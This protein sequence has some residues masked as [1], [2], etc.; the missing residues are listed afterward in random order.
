MSGLKV[1]LPQFILN[2]EFQ[3]QTPYFELQELILT[4]WLS[5][6]GFQ[7][8]SLTTVEITALLA[9][10]KPPIVGTL[11]YNSTLDKLQFLGSSAVQTVTSV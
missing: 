1:D 10:T 9:L 6:N 5:S 7:I 3:D 2:G 4:Q 11:W 8:P